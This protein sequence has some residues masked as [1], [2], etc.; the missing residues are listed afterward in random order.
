MSY[1]DNWRVC[2]L[3]HSVKRK[4]ARNTVFKGGSSEKSYSL[5]FDAAGLKSGHLRINYIKNLNNG[6]RTGWG[7]LKYMKWKKWIHILVHF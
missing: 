5:Y 6:I 2:I 4:A 3:G 1:N 7:N